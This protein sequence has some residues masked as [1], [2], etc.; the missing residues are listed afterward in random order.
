VADFIEF[1]DPDGHPL[2]LSYGFEIGKEPVRY[3]PIAR[4]RRGLLLAPPT[5]VNNPD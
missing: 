2:A 5:T 1:K 4:E 3:R